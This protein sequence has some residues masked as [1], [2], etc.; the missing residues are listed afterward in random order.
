M[1]HCCWKLRKQPSDIGLI[2]FSDFLRTMINCLCHMIHVIFENWVKESITQYLQQIQVLDRV[3]YH[4][5]DDYPN[6]WGMGA[7]RLHTGIVIADSK[8]TFQR[9]K[10]HVHRE[11][12]THE[13][14][15]WNDCTENNDLCWISVMLTWHHLG[16]KLCV[17]KVSL[18]IQAQKIRKVQMSPGHRS[19]IL[20]LAT[21]AGHSQN[22]IFQ[23]SN[24]TAAW[25]LAFWLQGIFFLLRLCS[26]RLGENKLEYDCSESTVRLVEAEC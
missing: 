11:R 2:F 25:H 6:L 19:Q 13:W 18:R 14:F 10:G 1:S 3:S 20:K 16:R 15:Q 17:Q 9:P 24:K 12:H 5:K 21:R 8:D 4:S 26:H 7:G 23:R 22:L